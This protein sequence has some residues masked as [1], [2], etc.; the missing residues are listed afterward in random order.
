MIVV[1][2]IDQTWYAWANGALE[3]ITFWWYA[4]PDTGILDH[5]Y[6]P[7]HCRIGDFRR[8]ISISHTIT[9]RF[10]TTLSKV[11][12]VDKRMN[13]MHFGSNPADFRIN[14]EIQI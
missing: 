7:H 10:F 2:D 6:L 5:F 9:S 8:F 11:T 14:P 4:V 1:M 13:P 3:V 12:Q